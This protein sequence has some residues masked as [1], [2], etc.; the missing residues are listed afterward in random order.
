MNHYET[1]GVSSDATPDD[2]KQAYRKLAKQHHPDAGGDAN[3][4]KQI[5]QA[6]EVLSD[7]HKRQQYDLQHD[8]RI[9]VSMNFGYG[10]DPFAEIIQGRYRAQ[11][12]QRNPDAITEINI[13]LQQAYHGTD[14]LVD[15]GYTKELLQI[16][17]G[18]RGGTKYRIKDKGPSR[19]K[20]LPPGDIIVK[21]NVIMPNNLSRNHNDLHIRLEITAI[22]AMVGSEID[23]QHMSGKL[24]KIKVPAGTQPN[25][26]LRMKGFGMPDPINQ[27]VFGDMYAMINVNIPK[28]TDPQKVQQLNNICNEADDK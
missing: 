7:A 16:H 25:A 18:V 10:F 21:V 1:L 15:L 4:F 22:Q 19:I 8:Q 26:K 9:H 5:S 6:Y 13:S 12:P 27:N 11:P 28:V 2:I 24:I 23:L 14:Y 20:D 3:V 17:P